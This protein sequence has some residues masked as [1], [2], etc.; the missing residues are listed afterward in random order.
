[1]D[2]LAILILGGLWVLNFSVVIHALDMLHEVRVM[3]RRLLH[4][5]RLTVRQVRGLDRFPKRVVL[6]AQTGPGLET[7]PLSALDCAWYRLEAGATVSVH[8]GSHQ[9]VL[10]RPVEHV[11]GVHALLPR[12]AEI[13]ISVNTE[14]TKLTSHIA[15]YRQE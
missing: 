6:R 15:R 1:M 12:P 2:D 10:V 13:L 4:A 3:R 5:P 7:A 8:P 9:P 11:R 14:A